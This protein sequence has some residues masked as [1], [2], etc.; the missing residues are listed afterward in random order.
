M[1]TLVKLLILAGFGAALTGCVVA[2]YGPRPR[3]YLAVPAPVVVVHPG[4]Y[5]PYYGPGY[6]RRW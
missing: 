2:P 4:F 1:R 5:G 6:Y 3:A